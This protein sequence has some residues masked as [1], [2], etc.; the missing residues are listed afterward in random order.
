MQIE[1]IATFSED[2]FSND[3]MAKPDDAREYL[4]SHNDL[5]PVSAVSPIVWDIG[6]ADV[7]NIPDII[8]KGD[9]L[10]SKLVM[11][12]IMSWDPYGVV[13]TPAKIISN[14]IALEDRYIMSVNNLIDVM[15]ED[16]SFVFIKDLSSY[17]L[18]PE[19]RV[20]ELYISESKYEDIPEYKKH[21][22]Q[23]N[24]SDDTIFFST[25]LV[26]CVWDLV[27]KNG[28]KGLVQQPF[29]FDEEAPGF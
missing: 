6:D 22:F 21:I 9:R 10:V 8:D 11:D 27:K 28:G 12:A 4:Y 20:S 24:G 18:P 13:F 19:L 26:N 15:D 14:S 3:I 7:N 1:K 25:E 23:V 2:L 5:I 29:Y 16:K 17:G